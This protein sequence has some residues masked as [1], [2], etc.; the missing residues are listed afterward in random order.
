MCTRCCWYCTQSVHGTRLLQT[1]HCLTFL[2]GHICGR[3]AIAVQS[4]RLQAETS[5]S[6]RRLQAT[7]KQKIL[8]CSSQ[9]PACIFSNRSLHT[10]G[11]KAELRWLTGVF[12]R[13]AS[14]ARN[15]L[16]AKHLTGFSPCRLSPI[17]MTVSEHN[18]AMW[19]RTYLCTRAEQ[20]LVAGSNDAIVAVVSYTAVIG[21]GPRLIVCLQVTL[22]CL[23]HS[24]VNQNNQSN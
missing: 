17:I 7:V 14:R 22:H 2:H 24:L 9:S 16:P 12:R 6:G 8:H 1:C 3:L 18:L 10:A 15:R 20:S 21:V 11:I 5:I 19:R 4:C 23:S 13:I